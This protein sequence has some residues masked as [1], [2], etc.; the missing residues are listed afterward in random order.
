[1]EWFPRCILSNMKKE[2]SNDVFFS[3]R[4][5]R[6]FNAIV[7]LESVSLF[8]FLC[9]SACLCLWVWMWKSETSGIP[10]LLL[11]IFLRQSLS[12]I[13]ELT[14]MARWPA[15]P[16]DHL[17]F[18]YSVLELKVWTLLISFLCGC[19]RDLQLTFKGF[20]FFK[21]YFF[22]HYTNEDKGF[23]L[24]N[25]RFNVLE[26]FLFLWHLFEKYMYYL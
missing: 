20:S 24:I 7:H 9:L 11:L 12:V 14:C 3:T 13:L 6:Y 8:V 25:R 2:V 4:I 15:S 17:V 5:L 10:Q 16:R 19:I 22:H 23:L 18:V 21:K 26:L 1:M